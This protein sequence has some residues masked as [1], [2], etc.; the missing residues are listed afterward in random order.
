MQV[1]ALPKGRGR[2]RCRGGALVIAE[3]VLGIHLYSQGVW[4]FGDWDK[5]LR[6]VV[7]QRTAS[8]PL[9]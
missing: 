5:A 6:D 1:T 4:L 7:Q 8:I 3:H 2:A 9:T